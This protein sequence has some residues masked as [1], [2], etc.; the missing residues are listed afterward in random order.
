MKVCSS[1]NRYT[2]ALWFNVAPFNFYYFMLHYLLL[3]YLLLR[4]LM[5]HYVNVALCYVPVF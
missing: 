4:Y 3:H 2:T 1:D 5:L